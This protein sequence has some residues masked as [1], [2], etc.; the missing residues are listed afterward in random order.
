MMVGY[1]NYLNNLTEVFVSFSLL[2]S[3]FEHSGRSQF[4][5]ENGS[6]KACG[7]ST[8]YSTIPEEIVQQAKSNKISSN[9]S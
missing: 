1:L 7:T 6:T 8:D 4:S 5:I 9:T 3:Y 2:K